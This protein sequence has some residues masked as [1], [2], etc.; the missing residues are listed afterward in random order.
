[1]GTMAAASVEAH[2]PKPDDEKKADR[3]K[4]NLTTITPTSDVLP[5]APTRAKKEPNTLTAA[6]PPY[7]SIRESDAKV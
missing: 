7:L 4:S 1:M 3:S 6:P 2:A 5:L